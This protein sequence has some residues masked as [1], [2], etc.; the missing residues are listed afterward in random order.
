MDFQAQ[1]PRATSAKSIAWGV[2]LI[3]L[4]LAA[5]TAPAATSVGFTVVLAWVLMLVGLTHVFSSWHAESLLA[6]TRRIAVGV[7]YFAVGILIYTHPLW[8]VTSLTMVIGAVMLADGVIGLVT[9]FCEEDRENSSVLSSVVTL[10]LGSMIINQWPSSSL[11]TI[12][13]LVGVNLLI[14]GMAQTFASGARHAERLG[15]T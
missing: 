10:L 13:T 14:A 9:Y 15:H 4:G 1:L 6:V 3:L 12:G 7:L 8:G 11:W 5:L 2:L